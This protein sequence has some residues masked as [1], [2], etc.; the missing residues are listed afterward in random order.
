MKINHKKN[1]KAALECRVPETA[2]PLW[3]L[4]FHAWDNLSGKHV[5]FGREFEALSSKEKE[6]A[7]NTNAEIMISTSL[8]L[9]FSAITGLNGYWEVAP[10]EP[11]YYWMPGEYKVRQN[12]LLKK[13][14]EEEN[15]MFLGVANATIGMP[16]S[17]QGYEEFCYRLF[18]APEEIDLLARDTFTEGM[19]LAKEHRDL[20]FDGIVNACDVAD[21]RGP[22]F[23]GAQ[24]DRWFYPYLSKWAE[25]IKEMG[26]YSILHS[27]GNLHPI[28]ENL[29]LSGINA[30]QAIDPVA[31]MDILLA[32]EEVG[33]RLCLCGN[34]DTGL[35]LTGPKDN[36][37][38][39][40]RKILL[41]CKDGGG[42][43]FG[44]SNAV[45]KETPKDHYLEMIRAYEEFA[46]Y[47]KDS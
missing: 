42:F 7:L 1:M 5:I 36:I 38:E 46:P 27:D 17:S 23:N 37:Y 30:L 21:N 14:C 15:L 40:T 4:E 29:A 31:G 8:D 2:V 20:G 9:N 32:K 35:L 41:D 16:S 3:E 45:I 13:Y 44:S 18:D 6:Y 43:V 28:L 11:A 26:L 22:F 19:E 24:M 39:D 25:A 34:L 47:K 12:K 33:S 10:S